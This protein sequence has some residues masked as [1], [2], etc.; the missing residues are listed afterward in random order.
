MQAFISKKGREIVRS[1]QMSRDVLQNT[2]AIIISPAQINCQRTIQMNG[3]GA[4]IFQPF[5]HPIQFF[6]MDLAYNI[7]LGSLHAQFYAH[8]STYDLFLT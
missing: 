3:N 4:N 7:I 1:L 2:E 6:G 5:H 8:A